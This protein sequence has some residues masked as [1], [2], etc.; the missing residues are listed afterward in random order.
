VMTTTESNDL[1]DFN[2]STGGTSFLRRDRVANVSERSIKNAGEFSAKGLTDEQ[3]LFYK[4]FEG[5]DP[6]TRPVYNASDAVR[7]LIGITLTQ[8][9]DL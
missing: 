6:N 5:Y 7:V 1:S 8:I 9:F 2:S 3:R 4:L